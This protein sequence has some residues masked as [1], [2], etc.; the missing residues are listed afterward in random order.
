MQRFSQASRPSGEILGVELSQDVK[1][2]IE[3]RAQLFEAV[4]RGA[5][6][7]FGKQRTDDLSRRRRSRDHGQPLGVC[8]RTVESDEG[9]EL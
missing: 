8:L 3:L 4:G 9:L 7:V 2:G 6:R 5:C 1:N